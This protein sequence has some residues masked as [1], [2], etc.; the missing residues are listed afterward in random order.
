MIRFSFVGFALLIGACASG[1]TSGSGGASS[2]ARVAGAPPPSR[3]SDV[4]TREEI[5]RTIDAA[6]AL[7]IIQRLRPRFLREVGGR[8]MRGSASTTPTVR[9][10]NEI[11]GG[12]EVLR[13]VLLSEVQEIRYY[14][15]V[16]ATARFGGM[17]GRPVIHIVRRG[18]R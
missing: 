7:D 13:T 4:I 11:A 3:S 14:S 5:E 12:I 8:S 15:P 6:S 10:D 17:D 16:D 9:L 2:P 1:S 18:G